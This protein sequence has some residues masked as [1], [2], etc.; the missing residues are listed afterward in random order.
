MTIE[1]SDLADAHLEKCHQ[2]V[3]RGRLH[4]QMKPRILPVCWLEEYLGAASCKVVLE[5]GHV[6]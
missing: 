3:S 5:E 2:F 4:L 6:G 1:D